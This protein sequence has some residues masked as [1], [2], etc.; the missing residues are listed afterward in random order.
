VTFVGIG[1][2]IHQFATKS[3]GPTISSLSTNPVATLSS[4][5]DTISSSAFASDTSSS[6]ASTSN[7]APNFNS[8]AVSASAKSDTKT[9]GSLKL[10]GASWPEL[11]RLVG[12][13]DGDAG[14]HSII[15]ALLS[16]ANLGDI[17][18]WFGGS[19]GNA[20]SD[21]RLMLEQIM[22]ELNQC[23]Y[24]VVNLATQCICDRPVISKRRDELQNNLSKWLKCGRVNVSG[25]TTEG[26]F[27]EKWQGV[28][29]ISTVQLGITP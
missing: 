18:Q 19:S 11:P 9:L 4:T 10:Y 20:I 14:L 7:P 28:F 3:G 16:A 1:T 27:G 24:K 5:S 21:S 15:D 22:G 8:A 6:S 13:S 25:K 17:G 2:D 23:N 29:V 26:M 12:D